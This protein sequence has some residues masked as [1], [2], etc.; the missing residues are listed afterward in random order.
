MVQAFDHRAADIVTRE[1]NLFRP[2]QQTSISPAEKTNPARFPVPRHFVRFSRD[3]WK[4]HTYEWVIA[5]KDVTAST[6]ART[7]IAAIIPL[8]GAGH[9][10]PVLNMEFEASR[11]P[12]DAALITANLNSVVFD[13]VSRQK[14]QTNHFSNYILEQIPVVP[15]ERYEDVLL[16][17]R[18]VAEIAREAVLELT[19]TSHDL[20]SFARD[21]EYTDAKGQAK[22]PFIWDERRRLTLRA[23]LDAIYFHLYGITDRDEVRYIYSTFPIVERE[24][25]RDWGHY[26]SRELCLA[27]M[28]AL[29]AGRPDEQIELPE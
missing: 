28:N 12:S 3:W 13:Y 20:A 5:F 22:P 14:V 6:N 29:N 15:L 21:M 1:A 10:L 26:A 19:Y 16:G 2:G 4:N 7:M 11:T 27:W 17:K 18:S 9:T 23:K 8:C 25:T 24:E